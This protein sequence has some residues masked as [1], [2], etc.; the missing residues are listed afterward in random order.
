M[1]EIEG[2][3]VEALTVGVGPEVEGVA[4]AVALEAVEGVGVGVDTE[5]DSS[6]G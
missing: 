5:T 3:V 4:G 1:A 6:K 2:G